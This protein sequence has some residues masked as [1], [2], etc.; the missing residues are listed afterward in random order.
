LYGYLKIGFLGFELPT[1]ILYGIAL[2]SFVAN[3]CCHLS[4][5][6]SCRKRMK[7]GLLSTISALDKFEQ[8]VK[9]CLG[10]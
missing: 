9:D 8:S 2:E 3:K 7:D 6:M 10:V 1:V 5:S 4:F